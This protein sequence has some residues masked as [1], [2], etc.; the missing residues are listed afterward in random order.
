MVLN[1]GEPHPMC[2][3]SV[4]GWANWLISDRRLTCVETL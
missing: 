4:L 2:D 1:W 3:V